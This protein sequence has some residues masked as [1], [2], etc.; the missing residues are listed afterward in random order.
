MGL[1]YGASGYQRATLLSFPIS[2]HKTSHASVATQ[3]SI[4]I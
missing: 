4:Q 3:G 2:H 1:G